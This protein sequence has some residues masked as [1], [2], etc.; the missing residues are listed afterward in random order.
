MKDVGGGDSLETTLMS[1]AFCCC[2]GV[3]EVDN[4]D[5]IGSLESD[6]FCR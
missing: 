6:E 5:E 1:M 2:K 4:K 3:D